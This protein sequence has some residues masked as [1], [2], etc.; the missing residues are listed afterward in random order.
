MKQRVISGIIIVAITIPVLYFGGILYN[1]AIGLLSIMAFH[2]LLSVKKDVSIPTIM[3]IVGMIC[4]LSFIFM[5]KE[6]TSLIFGLSYETLSFVYLVLLAPTLFFNNKKYN[7]T[8]AFY[9]AS[10]SIFMGVV[11]NLFIAL[12]NTSILQFIY[13]ILVACMT[14]VFALLGGILIGRHPLTKISPKK[15]IEGSIIGTIMSIIVSTTYYVTFIDSSKIFTIIIMS[16]ILSI[17]GQM[18]DLFF[19]L[20]KRENGIK[21]YSNL[22]PGH[23]GILDRLDS[24]IFILIAFIFMVQFL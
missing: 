21:D 19:S 14:D 8:S 1:I 9:L 5:S 3:K 16:L 23:G 22:I 15:T 7:V 10:I 13:I 12:Y 18:G 11:F 6:N 24:I 2:E 4:M 20:I 17:I